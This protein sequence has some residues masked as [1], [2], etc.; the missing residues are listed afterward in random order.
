MGTHSGCLTVQPTPALTATCRRSPPRQQARHRQGPPAGRCSRLGAPPPAWGRWGPARAPRPRWRPPQCAAPPA[1]HHAGHAAAAGCRRCPRRTW[2]SSQCSPQWPPSGRG[3]APR[4][5]V[6][7]SFPYCFGAGGAQHSP[8]CSAPPAARPRCPFQRLP[9][10]GA[11]SDSA[12]LPPPLFSPPS[13]LLD[14]AADAGPSVLSG[15]NC[16]SCVQSERYLAAVSISRRSITQ[17]R[18]LPFCRLLA[19]ELSCDPA[20]PPSPKRQDMHPLM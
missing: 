17:R 6:P 7:P 14:A 11:H 3:P 12:R 5:P 20:N 16:A 18:G 19:A 8:A 10:K 1:G 4:W 9:P 13:S 2:R 15:V